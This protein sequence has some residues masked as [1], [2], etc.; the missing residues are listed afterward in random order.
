MAVNQRVRRDVPIYVQ[1]DIPPLTIQNTS[2]IDGTWNVV[3]EAILRNSRVR[4][5]QIEV[6]LQ[7]VGILP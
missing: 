4:L 5:A 1:H 6:A 2:V 7:K 3:E